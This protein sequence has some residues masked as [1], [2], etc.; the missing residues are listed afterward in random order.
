[1]DKLKTLIKSFFYKLLDYYKN[2]GK[3]VF[4]NLK[5]V[6][7]SLYIKNKKVSRKVNINLDK[8]KP[9]YKKVNLSNLF[10]PGLNGIDY[11]NITTS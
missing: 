4:Q 10:V 9:G 2:H 8:K 1:M 3:F 6:G 7:K 11:V 5:Q